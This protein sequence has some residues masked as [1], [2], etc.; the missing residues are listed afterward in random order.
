LT[1][2]FENLTL[3]ERVKTAKE[4]T[5]RV[6]DHLLYLLALHENN[7]IVLYSPT[8]SSQI[9]TSYA[10]TAF[11]VFQRG[12]HQFEILRLCALWDRAELDKESIPTI[13]ELIDHNGV[14]E[15]LVQETASHWN[16]DVG[17]IL[18]P[19]DDPDLHALEI[20]MLKLSNEN[21]AKE[22]AQKARIELRKA[23]QDSRAISKSPQVITNL[24]N[25]HL[26]HSLSH[27]RREKA[28]PI[29]PMK[30]GDEREVLNATLPIVESLFCW[31][32]GC[33]FSFKESKDIDRENAEALWKGCSFN[34]VS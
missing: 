1:A 20:D 17:S 29:A 14:I 27:T 25:K 10:A 6:V 30:Y 11:N 2:S 24:R 28:S 4:K 34:I 23:I 16:G 18:N 8:L 26:A 22:Q 21:F 7:A 13:I 32:N 33:S 31:V 3:P 12:L 19:S 9:P 5:E 15:S